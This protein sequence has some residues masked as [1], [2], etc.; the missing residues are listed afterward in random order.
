MENVRQRNTGNLQGS[1]D[2]RLAPNDVVL[3]IA[4]RCIIRSGFDM[5]FTNQSFEDRTRAHSR[6]ALR[7]RKHEY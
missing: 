2:E 7:N 4:T 6:P 3:R 5:S 1:A